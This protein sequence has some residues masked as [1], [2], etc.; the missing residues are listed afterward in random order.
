[1]ESSISNQLQSLNEVT[2]D[3]VQCQ[4]LRVNKRG[5][6]RGEKAFLLVLSIFVLLL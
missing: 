5:I 4:S 6:A 2:R 1:M 3:L